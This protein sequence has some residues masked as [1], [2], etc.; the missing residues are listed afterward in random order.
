MLRKLGQQDY[1]QG[2]ENTELILTSFSQST[3]LC[4]SP[5]MSWVILIPPFF[6]YTQPNLFVM[7]LEWYQILR[8]SRNQMNDGSIV[9]FN[10][11]T[12]IAHLYMYICIH[13]EDEKRTCHICSI[14]FSLNCYLWKFDS[15]IYTYKHINI[16]TSYIK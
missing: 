4:H 13:L 2:I 3:C 12:H 5:R 16:Y 1:S 6:I 11:L 8:F 7:L 9:G 14:P 15:S 10:S